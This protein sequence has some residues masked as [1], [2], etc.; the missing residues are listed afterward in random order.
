MT[1]EER[2]KMQSP[3]LAT[4]KSHVSFS[5][6]KDHI[7]CS[8]RHKLKH[9]DKIDLFEENVYTNFGTA[10]HASCEDYLLTREMKHEIA[11]EEIVRLWQQYD[12]PEMGMYMQSANK[13]LEAVPDFLEQRFP[14]WETVEAEE[15]LFEPLSGNHKD[16]YFKGYIDAIIKQKGIYWIIDWKTAAEGWNKYKRNDD[17]LKMQLMLYHNYWTKKHGKDFDKVKV[18]FVILNRKLDAMDRIDYFSFPV[19]QEKQKKHLK[20]LDDSIQQLKNGVAI[21]NWKFGNPQ[22]QGPC[23]FCD[24]N[25]TRWCP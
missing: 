20:I 16:V 3:S 22:L 25:N 17:L 5:E 8:Y 11:L 15:K 9:I 4:G 21:K 2:V 19:E 18:G 23:R 14:G 6:I 7:E 12:L 24:Y 10:I 1:L 13:I